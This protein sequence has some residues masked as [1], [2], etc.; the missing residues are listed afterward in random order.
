MTSTGILGVKLPQLE[1]LTFDENIMNWAAFWEWFNALIHSKKQVD[2]VEILTYLGQALKDGPARH[3][4]EGLSQTAKNY[5]EAIKCLQERYDQ[6]WLIHQAHVHAITDVPSLKDG[7]GKELQQLHDVA[8][9]HMMAIQAIG[10]SPWTFITFIL[11]TKPDQTTMFEWQKHSQ[12][13]KQVP[14]YTA[15]LEF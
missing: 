13:S 11:E 5:V 2:H 7:D 9:Q 1:V 14:D 3:I 4:L 12:D 6:P 8:D 15:L 10:H